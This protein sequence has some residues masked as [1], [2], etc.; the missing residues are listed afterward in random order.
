ME[1]EFI[2]TEECK[3]FKVS[4]FFDKIVRIE[5]K[6]H[7]EITELDVEDLLNLL[8]KKLGENK[9]P[10]MIVMNEFTNL[11]KEAKVLSASERGTKNSDCEAIIVNNFGNKL[12]YKMYMVINKP[13]VL[14]NV[15][16]TAEDG[17]L[18]LRINSK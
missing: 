1:S 13:N 12:I 15:F 4:Q 5:I 3:F 11:T 18:W 17:L 8:Q 14:T 9:Y 6:D 16:T 7:K 10:T 2:F